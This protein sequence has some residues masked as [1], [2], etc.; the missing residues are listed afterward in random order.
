MIENL[1]NI[2]KMVLKNFLKMKGRDG[3]VKNVEEWSVFI[4]INVILVKIN[5]VKIYYI[6]KLMR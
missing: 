5:K 2:Q 6:N 1:E 3:N 4:T